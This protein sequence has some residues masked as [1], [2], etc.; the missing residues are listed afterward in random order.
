MA[1]KGE[2]VILGI[3]RDPAFGPVVMFGL[4]GLFV[5]IFK[6]VQ[7]RIAPLG[8]HEALGMI[9]KIKGYPLLKGARGKNPADI[10]R[11]VDCIYRLSQLAIDFPEISELD[12][13]PIIV[14]DEGKGCVVVDAK[15]MF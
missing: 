9:E 4:G 1:E 14:Y 2:E 12:V 6:D 5:E 10:K 7:F 8:E 3:K 11:L 15:I 13:N